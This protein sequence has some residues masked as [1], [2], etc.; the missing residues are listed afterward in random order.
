[1]VS[2]HAIALA[3]FAIIHATSTFPTEI[4][5]R[6]NFT[7]GVLNNTQEFYITMRTTE[8]CLEKYNGWQSSF[9]FP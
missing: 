8:S 7:P 2:F 5:G 6:Q 3:S 4:A 1:M 9:S